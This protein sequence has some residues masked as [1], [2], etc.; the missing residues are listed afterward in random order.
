MG[1]IVRNELI[2]PVWKT[3]IGTWPVKL[4]L[5]GFFDYGSVNVSLSKPVQWY[6]AQEAKDP[7]T[8]LMSV[9]CGLRI[10]VR[11]NFELRFDYGFQLTDDAALRSKLGA[12]A[13]RSRAHIGAVVR[14]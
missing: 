2:T 12:S 6:E 13:D 7:H 9:G 1:W 14:F 5:L 11:R 10:L 4:W 3:R 8:D